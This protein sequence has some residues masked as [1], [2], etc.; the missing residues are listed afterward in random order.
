[1]SLE[2]IRNTYCDGNNRRICMLGSLVL[3]VLAQAINDDAQMFY[4]TNCSSISKYVRM[5]TCYIN[6]ACKYVH[7]LELM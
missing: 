7:M 1:M 5:G 6:R 3:S 4:K 2:P